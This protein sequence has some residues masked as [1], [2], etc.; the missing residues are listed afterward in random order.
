LSV[1]PR[2]CGKPNCRCARGELHSSLYLVQSHDGKPRQLCIPKPWEE[3]VRQAVNDFQE[4]QRLIEEISELE[5]KRVR[6]KTP[7]G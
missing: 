1:R 6:E 2:K 5:W 7:P 4:M 3:R